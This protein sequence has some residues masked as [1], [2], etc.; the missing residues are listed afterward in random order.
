M[1]TYQDMKNGVVPSVCSL[2]CPD[3]CG[4]LVHKQDGKLLKS[5]VIPIILLL[6]GIFATKFGIWGNVFTIRN[7]F[8]H[9]LKRVG[10][11]GDGEFVPISWEEA[12]ETITNHWKKL[13]ARG[14]SRI[15]SSLQLLWKYG[16]SFA[17]GMDRRFFNHLGSSQLD[18]TICSLLGTVGYNYTMG[19]SYGT[20]PEDMTETKLFI[21]W[22]I[23]AVSTNMHQI[24]IAQKARKK[25]PKS[26]SSTSIKIKRDVWQIGLFRFFQGLMA[27]LR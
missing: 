21:F 22:G 16:E 18:R 26:S 20:D 25:G 9:P 7:E 1:E 17:E 13:I 23:N 5:K 19:G 3:Q 14:R 4:L 12:I 10:Q 2:D 24:T 11:K 15:D 6:K 27:H 8:K